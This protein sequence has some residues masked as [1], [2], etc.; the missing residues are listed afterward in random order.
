MRREKKRLLLIVCF[1]LLFI[2][3]PLYA[4]QNNSR[5][6]DKQMVMIEIIDQKT[7]ETGS[8]RLP[9]TGEALTHMALYGFAIVIVVLLLYQKKKERSLDE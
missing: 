9:Q 1:I 5:T 4:A 7:T 2:P 6:E 8:G 3:S